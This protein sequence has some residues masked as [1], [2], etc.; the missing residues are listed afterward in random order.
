M[1]TIIIKKISQHQS[2]GKTE[3][4]LT[5]LLSRYFNLI[6]FL[7]LLTFLPKSDHSL[8]CQQHHN[9]IAS[10]DKCCHFF[11]IQR[12]VCKHCQVIK[13]FADHTCILAV[14]MV[15]NILYK[16]MIC[17]QRLKCSLRQDPCP[18]P[19]IPY[20][21]IISCIRRLC[22]DKVI[23][24]ATFSSFNLAIFTSSLSFPSSLRKI[25]IRLSEVFLNVS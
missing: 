18:C 23:M 15:Y 21:F 25:S 6:F 1:Q 16:W 9:L 19:F 24:E 7:S 20:I 17:I 2:T 3:H 5:F 11:W 4:H 13:L 8:F 10:L 22:S 14:C 12:F